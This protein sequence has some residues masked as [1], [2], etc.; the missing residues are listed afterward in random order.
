MDGFS[1]AIRNLCLM[2]SVV[3]G[4]GE[5]TTTAS[6]TVLITDG[7]DKYVFVHDFSISPDDDDADFELDMPEYRDK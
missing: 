6:N 2:D 7:M 1:Q 4:N 3:G 5:L